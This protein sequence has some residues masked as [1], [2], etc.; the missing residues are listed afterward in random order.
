MTAKSKAISLLLSA[1][2]RSVNDLTVASYLIA[3]DDYTDDEVKD[4]VIYAIK[5]GGIVEADRRRMYYAGEIAGICSRMRREKAESE[6]PAAL[7]QWSDV[8]EVT[9]QERER[10]IEKVKEIQLM[11]ARKMNINDFG[12]IN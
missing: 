5:A 12:G 11:L 2:G 4:A 7:A 1:Y 10:N 9:D 8:D 3:V 6:K